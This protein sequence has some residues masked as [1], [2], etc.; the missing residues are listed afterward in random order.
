MATIDPNAIRRESNERASQLNDDGTGIS[1]AKELGLEEF[2]EL[3]VDE[4]ME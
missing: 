3:D 2:A 1:E 4:R